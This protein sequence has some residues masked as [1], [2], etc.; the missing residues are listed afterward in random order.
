MLELLF[1]D[2]NEDESVEREYRQDEQSEN[3]GSVSHGKCAKVG[4]GCPDQ[5]E[6]GYNDCEEVNR[7][8]HFVLDSGTTAELAAHDC[9]DERS[10]SPSCKHLFLHQHPAWRFGGVLHY[11]R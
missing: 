7:H 4:G 8:A 10:R 9:D 2:E 6:C 3:W 11:E 1:G 5:D